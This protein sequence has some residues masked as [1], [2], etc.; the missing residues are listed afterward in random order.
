MCFF[1]KFKQLKEEIS[2][3]LNKNFMLKFWYGSFKVFGV[4]VLER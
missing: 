1:Y 2:K 4:V 3:S